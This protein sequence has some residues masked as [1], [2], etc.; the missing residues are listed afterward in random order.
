MNVFKNLFIWIEKSLIP[1]D[2]FIDTNNISKKEINQFKETF[3][4]IKIRTEFLPKRKIYKFTK[5]LYINS[6]KL[7]NLSY[8]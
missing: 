8:K 2:I 5:Q 3:S 6:S 4:H 1:V 7:N